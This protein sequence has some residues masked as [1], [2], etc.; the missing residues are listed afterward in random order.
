MTNV[1]CTHSNILWRQKHIKVNIV[2]K[3]IMIFKKKTNNTSWKEQETIHS[4]S[5]TETRRSMFSQKTV[6]LTHG[7][8]HPHDHV[9]QNGL[10]S[11]GRC[12]AQRWAD[13]GPVSS[14]IGERS[15]VRC[16]ILSRFSPPVKN[17]DYKISRPWALSST[18]SLSPS[19]SPRGGGATE[20]RLA[21]TQKVHGCLQLL[22]HS[23]C[24]GCWLCC[25][26]AGW[27]GGSGGPFTPGW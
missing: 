18:C 27:F 15:S 17:D 8:L 25:L 6:K 21:C 23:P 26:F 13:R 22:V 7:A 9:L 5:P 11:R 16:S 3:P 12:C 1:F 4:K 14:W 19:G 2:S 10:D 24:C 20:V